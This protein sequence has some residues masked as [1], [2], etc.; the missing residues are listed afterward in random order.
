MLGIVLLAL[1]GTGVADLCA[2]AAEPHGEFT[3]ARHEPHRKSADICAIA[4]ELDA[5]RHHLYVLLVQA[6]G[7]AVLASDRAGNA[8]MDATL[9]FLMRHIFPLPVK[10][11]R[12]R[13]LPSPSS[14]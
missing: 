9:V 5:T 3:A 14:A 11:D 4:V 1:G 7:C 12:T 8:R 10:Q 2:K 6:F 13:N